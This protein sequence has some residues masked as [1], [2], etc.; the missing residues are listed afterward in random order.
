M[1]LKKIAF[2]RRKPT[3]SVVEFESHWRTTHGPIVANTPGYREHRWRYVQD[4]VRK[5]GP[6]GGM[7]DWNGIAEFWLPTREPNEDSF[8]QL[9]I[10]RDRIQVDER[11]FID[12]DATVSMA[13][14][15]H[16]IIPGRGAIKAMILSTLAHSSEPARI[17]GGALGDYLGFLRHHPSTGL[18]GLSA[19]L[20]IPGTFRLPGAR[21]TDP[22]RI[23]CIETFWFDDDEAATSTFAAW[24]ASPDFR[25][26]RE[27]AFDPEC[28]SLLAEELI[29][30]ENGE[31]L[32]APVPL[33]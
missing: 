22:L 9:P 32:V 18:R 16:R 6:L 3:L 27:A 12:M 31:P 28:Q 4:H 5:P 15:E 2:L 21:Q 26:L 8:S 17:D 29:F 23:D 19:D 13:A 1:Q 30:F 10:Y 11:N 20:V 14:Y 24:C 33:S 25:G 7:F